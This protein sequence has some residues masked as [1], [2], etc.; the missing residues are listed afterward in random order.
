M[1]F[2]R[3]SELENLTRQKNHLGNIGVD[4]NI[5]LKYILKKYGVKL[6]AGFMWPVSVDQLLDFQEELYRA[7]SYRTNRSVSLFNHLF[8]SPEIRPLPHIR[9][10]RNHSQSKSGTKGK[11]SKISI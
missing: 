7:V 4:G 10:S 8:P 6:W 2:C 9:M 1:H 5:I 3:Q 11:G